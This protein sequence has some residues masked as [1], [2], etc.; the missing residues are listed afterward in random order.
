MGERE[1]IDSYLAAHFDATPNTYLLYKTN[2]PHIAQITKT[3]EQGLSL[4][5]EKEKLNE[6]FER[7]NINEQ[8]K[9][10]YPKSIRAYPAKLLLNQLHHQWPIHK[11]LPK[12]I[13]QRA[14]FEADNTV[15]PASIYLTSQALAN[16]LQLNA[17]QLKDLISIIDPSHKHKRII[18]PIAPIDI[19]LVLSHISASNEPVCKGLT[20]D[21]L[22]KGNA[23]TRF[24]L[25]KKVLLG[26]IKFNYQPKGCFINSIIIQNN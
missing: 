1:I 25:L 22:S 17:L 7:L 12:L 26:E 23:N 11:R 8:G 20:I 13:N 18:S 6:W 14:N 3:I 16:E 19:S 2:H 4:L 9:R 21:Q 24:Q 10:C 5:N 15:T